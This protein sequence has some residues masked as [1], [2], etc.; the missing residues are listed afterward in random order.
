MLCR[1]L[2]IK[3]KTFKTTKRQ[4]N[5]LICKYMFVSTCVIKVV[6]LISV[7]IYSE[8]KST[9]LNWMH[10]VLDC[11]TRDR[12]YTVHSALKFAMRLYGI[13]CGAASQIL[14][15]CHYLAQ[16]RA[17]HIPRDIIVETLKKE[18][19][20]VQSWHLKR[21]LTRLISII[22]AMVYISRKHTP[23][24]TVELCWENMDSY[25]K[26]TLYIDIM[27]F[28]AGIYQSYFI[29]S[30]FSWIPPCFVH[31]HFHLRKCIHPNTVSVQSAIPQVY[32]FL[33]D[34]LDMINDN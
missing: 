18:C 7:L 6:T 27:H 3:L 21:C 28:Y 11:K 29:W 14:K 26:A 34:G 15:W 20:M 30:L 19:I 24:G 2:R 16:S 5:Q 10:P 23:Q 9:G 22:M 1:L 13:W 33:L 31:L 32:E 12:F 8:A 4:L 25:E 17:F